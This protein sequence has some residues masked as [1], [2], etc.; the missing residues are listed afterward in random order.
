MFALRDPAE[1]NRRPE[2]WRATL[3]TSTG[4]TSDAKGFCI[5]DSPQMSNIEAGKLA[6]SMPESFKR[7]S[8][9]LPSWRLDPTGSSLGRAG[10]SEDTP[11]VLWK[12]PVDAPGAPREE[13]P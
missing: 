1:A 4:R 2:A 6:L 7:G 12:L 9:E 3:R 13:P 8:F 10:G 5:K 11:G